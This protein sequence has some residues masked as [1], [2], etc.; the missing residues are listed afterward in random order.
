MTVGSRQAMLV[1]RI[2]TVSV[3]VPHQL[4]QSPAYRR[5]QLLLPARAEESESSP[6]SEWPK[7]PDC[8][9]PGSIRRGMPPAS[10]RLHSSPAR[11]QDVV[12]GRVDTVLESSLAQASRDERR[13]S[14]HQRWIRFAA[15]TALARRLP[16]R[17]GFWTRSTSS[18]SGCLLSTTC[19]DG[20]STSKP[21]IAAVPVIRSTASA[22]CCTV[23]PTAHAVGRISCLGQ[24]CFAAPLTS[25][26]R[27]ES[28][29]GAVS[30]SAQCER[31]CVPRPRA[32]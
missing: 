19:G 21:G 9:P 12:P 10:P 28:A 22:W 26:H 15:T 16:T 30:L 23:A 32:R 8:A 2:S 17:S 27:Q 6:R 18:S 7:P 25:A 13:G 4:S 11:L 24:T 20:S 14:P 1:H 29:S 5:R 3:T 31:A